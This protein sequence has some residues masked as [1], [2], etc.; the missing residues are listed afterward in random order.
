MLKFIA[1]ALCLF[2]LS[3]TTL[4]LRDESELRVS[5]PN[6]AVF[7]SEKNI[8]FPHVYRHFSNLPRPFSS[9]PLA[10]R[11][12]FFLFPPNRPIPLSAEVRR[13]QAW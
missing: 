5:S 4:A 11:E 3:S 6:L 7:F 13:D 2:C 12:S 8:G 9:S 10:F 1:I